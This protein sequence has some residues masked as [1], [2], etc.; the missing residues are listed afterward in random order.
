MLFLKYLCMTIAIAYGF[1]NIVKVF[2][3][4]AVSAPCIWMMAIGIVGYVLL[5]FELGI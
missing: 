3:G 1:S 2:R 5:K 4:K